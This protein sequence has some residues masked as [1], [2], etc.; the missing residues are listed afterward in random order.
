MPYMEISLTASRARLW[1]EGK[2]AY[3]LSRRNRLV[4]IGPS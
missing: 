4:I 3:S 1:L 2:K